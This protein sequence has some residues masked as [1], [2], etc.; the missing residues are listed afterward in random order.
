MRKM[1]VAVLA[2]GMLAATGGVLYSAGEAFGATATCTGTLPGSTINANVYVPSG[3]VCTISG[4]TVNGNITVEPG[5]G[6]VILGS[7]INGNVSAMDPGSFAGTPCGGGSGHFSVVV[8]SSTISGTVTV[9]GAPNNSD[10]TI[11]GN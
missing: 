6:L 8:G 1:V 3:S 9:T 2:A 5:G 10:V 7:K 11:G 4:Q